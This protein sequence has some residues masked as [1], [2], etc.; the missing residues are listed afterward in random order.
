MWLRTVLVRAGEGRRDRR[1][2]LE[3]D[4]QVLKKLIC[5]KP[6]LYCPKDDTEFVLH[7]DAS[8][9]GIGAVLSQE[10]EK[11]EERPIAFFSRKLLPRE[12]RY[13]RYRE[14]MPGI[15]GRNQAL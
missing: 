3:N 6:I 15:G 9:R 8:E 13:Y 12:T 11:D 4:F 14:R 2:T 1:W 5:T 7:T 10:I